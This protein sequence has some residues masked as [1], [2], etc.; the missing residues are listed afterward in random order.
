MCQLWE[1]KQEEDQSLPSKWEQMGKPVSTL[2]IKSP[3]K[4]RDENEEMGELCGHKGGRKSRFY[5]G[6]SEKASWKK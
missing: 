3:A 6:Q 5:L 2:W 4:T 1:Y